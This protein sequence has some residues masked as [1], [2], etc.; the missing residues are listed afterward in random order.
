MEPGDLCPGSFFM[1]LSGISLLTTVR[2]HH[3]HIYYLLLSNKNLSETFEVE[4][5]MRLSWGHANLYSL[6]WLLQFC[7]WIIEDHKICG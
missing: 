3:L 6:S 5:L 1:N 2:G 4:V 7:P